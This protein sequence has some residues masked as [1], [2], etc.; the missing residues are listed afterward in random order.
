MCIPLRVC[1]CHLP[2]K[3]VHFVKLQQ[4]DVSTSVEWAS[5]GATQGAGYTIGCLFVSVHFGCAFVAS[6]LAHESQHSRSFLTNKDINS[7]V[8]SD[9]LP[10]AAGQRIYCTGN[11]SLRC[12]FRLPSLLAALEWPLSHGG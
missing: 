8:N 1:V 5:F 12:P 2:M 10:S 9:V 6:R 7:D 3:A 11:N 4:S